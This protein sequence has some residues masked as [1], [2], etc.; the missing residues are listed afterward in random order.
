MTRR[1]IRPAVLLAATAALLASAAL[2]GGFGE[3]GREAARQPGVRGFVAT[4][5]DY[6]YGS[7]DQATDCPDGLTLGPVDSALALLPPEQR[8]KAAPA[9]ELF[10]QLAFLT[11]G[12]P[13]KDIPLTHNACTHPAEFPA[14]TGH[15]VVEHSGKAQGLDL[16]GSDGSSVPAGTC[17]HADFT[18]ADGRRTV[19]NQLW[20]AI[21]CTRG[22]RKAGDPERNG[23]AHI[24][25]G[26][27]LVLVEI[28]GLDDDRNDP[29]VEVGLYRGGDRAA[30]D[31]NGG[32]AVGDS[33]HVDANPKYQARLKGRVE[34]GVLSTDPGR[35]VLTWDAPFE[36]PNDL[37]I[38]GARLR[39]ELL[40]DGRAK[41]VL[42]G[43]F[44]VEA[45]YR[46]NIRSMTLP[47]SLTEGFTCPGMLDT[48]RRLAD[49]LADPATGKCTAISGAMQIEL[50]PAFVVQDAQ[51]AAGPADAAEGGLM[52]RLWRK[53][54]GS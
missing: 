42:A 24:R 41:G 13:A 19:D 33:L 11:P 47:G 1:T 44:P 46:S 26:G 2:A 35:V 45:F 10:A 43:Y 50:Q 17:A 9:N 15:R 40:P 53:V 21:G 6:A 20:R 39:V 34:N 51:T 16:D 30:L 8:A 32:V 4:D 52:G 49:G 27:S 12:V 25:L 14:F 48:L 3:P 31:A 7:D 5:F 36:P 22:F 18:G 28:R 54:T 38:E 23:L 29:E 37:V